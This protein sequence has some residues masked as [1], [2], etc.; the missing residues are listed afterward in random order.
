M[1]LFSCLLCLL[2]AWA[3]IYIVVSARWQL[4]DQTWIL[5]EYQS[6]QTNQIN[7]RGKECTWMMDRFTSWKTKVSK[8]V[9]NNRMHVLEWNK[10]IMYDNQSINQSMRKSHM[11]GPHQSPIYLAWIGLTNFI[12]LKLRKINY[13]LCKINRNRRLF[14]NQSGIKIVREKIGFVKFIWKIRVSK[15]T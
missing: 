11:L 3:S 14:E 2:V 4:I 12:I 9:Q 1:D 5:N 10:S 6:K 13:S 8:Q 15:N 7:K